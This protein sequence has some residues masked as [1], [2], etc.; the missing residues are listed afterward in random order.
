MALYVAAASIV[1]LSA[2][3]RSIMLLY[4]LAKARQEDIPAII[5]ASGAHRIGLISWT[6]KHFGNGTLVSAVMLHEQKPSHRAL[7]LV[8]LLPESGN[9]RFCGAARQAGD[10]KHCQTG[11][12]EG[13]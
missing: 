11:Q 10:H 12:K 6:R 9:R 3:A 2:T 7:G 5:R 8:L 1:A 4:A 13:F